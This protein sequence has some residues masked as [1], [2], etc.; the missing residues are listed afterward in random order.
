MG[1]CVCF[2]ACVC[3][4][5]CIPPTYHMNTLTNTANYMCHVTLEE[6][7]RESIVHHYKPNVIYYHVGIISFV[8]HVLI[9]RRYITN[10]VL[11]KLN[12]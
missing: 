7:F 12:T 3:L 6:D 8:K 5:V 1:V 11:E 4:C 2:C 10:C 9:R